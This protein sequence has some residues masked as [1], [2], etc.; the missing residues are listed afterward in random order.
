MIVHTLF[1]ITCKCIDIKNVIR[2]EQQSWHCIYFIIVGS[3]FIFLDTLEVATADIVEL[4]VL[5][6][7]IGMVLIVF[8][9]WFFW[10]IGFWLKTEYRFDL[11]DLIPYVPSTISQFNRDGS[12]LVEPVL[13]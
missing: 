12:S 2:Y 5:S 6:Q 7:Y 1:R 9:F 8:I 13:S 3:L 10:N 11:F 4:I